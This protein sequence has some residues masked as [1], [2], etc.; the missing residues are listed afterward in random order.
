MAESSLCNVTQRITISRFF[1]ALYVANLFLADP[2][3]AACATNAIA[4]Q[5]NIPQSLAQAEYN[6]A[7]DPLTG[8]TSSPG[9]N[10]TVSTQGLMNVIDVRKQFGGFASVPADFDYADA[11]QPGPG[12]L[13]D[14]SVRDNVVKVVSKINTDYKC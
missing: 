7:T 1:G 12:K 3:N 6:A 5:L 14:Y 4:E 11:I 2:K 10:F 13:I 8:E 9:G